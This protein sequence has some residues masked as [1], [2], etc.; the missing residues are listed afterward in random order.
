MNNEEKMIQMMTQMLSE[1]NQVKATQDKMQ[2]SIENLQTTQAKMQTTIE[3]L[4][5]DI[6]K[7]AVIMENEVQPDIKLL[8]EGHGIVIRRLDM[9]ENKISEIDDTVSVLKLL[10]AKKQ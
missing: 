10:T 6:L 4:D 5:M 8:G 9:L 2:T 3:K 1:L 7:V